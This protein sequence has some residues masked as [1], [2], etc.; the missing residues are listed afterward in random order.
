MVRCPAIGAELFAWFVDSLRNIKGRIPSFLLLDV[1]IGFAKTL[2]QGHERDKEDGIVPPHEV[3]QLPKLNY[4]WLRRWRRMHHVTWRTVT[5][6][7][8][9]CRDTLRTRLLVFWKNVLRVRFFA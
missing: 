4:S 5:F 6:R 3:L 9:C 2:R 1:A 8:K 7:F